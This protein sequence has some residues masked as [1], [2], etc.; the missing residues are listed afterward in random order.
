MR[1]LVATSMLLLFLAAPMLAEKGDRA[2]S[3]TETVLSIQ[4]NGKVLQLQNFT[5]G[6]KLEVLN[7]VGV[8]VLERKLD[9]ANQTVTLELPKGYYIVKIGATVRKIS[10]K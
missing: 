7:I 3:S 2:V 6:D 4:Q 10:I 8:K 1:K 5:A 9:S